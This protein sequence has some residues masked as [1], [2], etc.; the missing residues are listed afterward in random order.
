MRQGFVTRWIAVT[1][2][3]SIVCAVDQGWVMKWL[4]LAP[5]RVFHG[6][7]WRLV[8]WALIVPRPI[9]LIIVGYSIYKFG[10][11]LSAQ[12]GPGRLRAFAIEVIALSA[13]ATCAL[14]WLTGDRGAHTCSSLTMFA[15]LIAW[16]RQFPE[17]EVV[18]YGVVHVR[19]KQLIKYAAVVV[20]LCAIYYG[21]YAF[22]PE[23]AAVGLATIWP[24]RS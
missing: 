17:R 14:A 7:V 20:V 16:A 8:T 19:G 3:V 18:L 12:W 21:P 22:A 2:I 6:E 9:T 24:L 1:V 5:D 13:L 10:G 11:E 4:A 23:L 15:L